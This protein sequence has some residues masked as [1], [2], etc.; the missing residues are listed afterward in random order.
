[1]ECVTSAHFA[2]LWNGRP[3]LDIYPSRGLRQGDPIS[4]YLF[5]IIMERLTRTINR[6]VSTR[7]WDPIVLSRGGPTLSH[8]LFADDV[9]IMAQANVTTAKTVNKVLHAFAEEAGLAINLKRISRR[10]PPWRAKFLNKAARTTLARSVLSTIPVYFMQIA[11][12][13]EKTC[14]Q[15]DSIIKRFIWKDR[16]GRG[17]HLVKWQTVA[18]PRRLGGLGLRQTRQMNIAMLGKKVSEYIEGTPSLWVVALSDRF[19]RGYEGIKRSKTRSSSVWSALRRCF[20]I[21]A[22][23]FTYRLGNGE[24]NFWEG[25]YLQGKPIKCLVYYVHISD[26]D[27]SCRQLIVNGRFDLQSLHTSFPDHI[28]KALTD[29]RNIYLHPSVP[30][31]WC[32]SVGSSGKYSVATCYDWLLQQ[33]ADTKTTWKKIWRPDVPEKINIFCWLIGHWSLPTKELRQRRHLDSTGACTICGDGTET[34]VHMFFECPWTAQVWAGLIHYGFPYRLAHTTPL[35]SQALDFIVHAPAG[36]R[37]ALWFMWVE[38]NNKVFGKPSKS[39]YAVV[40]DILSFFQW[41][42]ETRRRADMLMYG[43][44][45]DSFSKTVTWNPYFC[46]GMILYTDGSSMGNPGQSCFGAVLRNHEGVWIEGISGNIGI[47][48]NSL[49][50]VVAILEGLNLAVARRCTTL[51]CLLRLARGSPADSKGIR[52]KSCYG[53]AAHEHHGQD[54]L[55]WECAVFP[56]MERG[57]FCCRYL[58]S[59]RSQGRSILY[60]LGFSPG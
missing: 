18:T 26:S 6:E 60:D 33:G 51:T 23:G 40:R 5:V 14:Q 13:P 28:I 7:N 43:A 19:G 24:T 20:S 37:F 36:L 29:A 16:D 32:W 46:T 30:D 31:R 3:S 1:M 56:H 25:I 48:D 8:L 53:R 41:W 17:L 9:L 55:D 21:I 34:W 57:K 4:P 50:E 58:G 45:Q 22:N 35:D 39:P 38:R 15:I 49:A 12:F 59:E 52:S 42:R 10:L 44:S 47:S 54:Q 27:K 2:I 11:W